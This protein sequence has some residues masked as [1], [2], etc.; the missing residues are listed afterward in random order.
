MDI[1]SLDEIQLNPLVMNSVDL[2]TGRKFTER[3][4]ERRLELRRAIENGG[5]PIWP[6]VLL[7]EG[8]VLIDGHCRLSTLKEM[9]IPRA[10]SYTGHL[11]IKR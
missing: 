4:S 11:I 7:G 5:I 6:L 3:L 8:Q 10:Y 1:V 2:K 9:E